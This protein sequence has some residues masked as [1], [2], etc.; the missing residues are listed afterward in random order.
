MEAEKPAAKRHRTKYDVAFRTEAVRR[1]T[2]DGQAA[3]RV[4]QALGMSEAVL[5]KWVRA[6]R[7]YA[8]RPAGSE[9]LEQ[10]N[11]QNKKS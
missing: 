4:A 9:A 7:T 8:A 2:Q 10:E 6:A 5:G 11:K 1:V 3:T